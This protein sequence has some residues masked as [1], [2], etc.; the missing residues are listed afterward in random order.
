MVRFS[1][2]FE[3]TGQLGGSSGLGWVHSCDWVGG[4]MDRPLVLAGLSHLFEGLAG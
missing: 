1:F 3:A 2:V 4:Q